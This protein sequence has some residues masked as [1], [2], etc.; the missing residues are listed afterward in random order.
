MLPG[1]EPALTRF[2]YKHFLA[3]ARLRKGEGH[4]KEWSTAMHGDETGLWLVARHC[5][6]RRA[7]W[8]KN[9][10][11][12]LKVRQTAEV[13][14]NAGLHASELWAEL[15]SQTENRRP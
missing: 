7:G 6:E 5:A 13:T 12:F 15:P 8:K 14:W 9:G 3:L 2:R 10:L 1:V 4:E 11:S